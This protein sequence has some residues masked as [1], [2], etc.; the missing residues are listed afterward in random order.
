MLRK[1]IKLYGCCLSCA[2]NCHKGHRLV[3]RPAGEVNVACD[4][5]RNRHQSAVTVCTWHSTKTEF[6]KQPFYCCYDCFKDP[7]EG[8]CYQCVSVCPA[9]HNTR[10][11]G[12]KKA[13]CDCGLEGCC[14]ILCRIPHP[15]ARCTYET[16]GDT[17]HSQ[18]WY[19]CCT[20]W[21]G[22]SNYVYRCC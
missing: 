22:E 12:I 7:L 4:C 13:F 1:R 15:T 18:P 3:Y 8:C 20:C 10:F 5:G 17:Y 16:C 19:E 21:G 6:V 14:R 9:G 2:F 11:A